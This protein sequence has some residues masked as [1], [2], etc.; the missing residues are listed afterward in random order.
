MFFILLSKDFF[1]SARVR[2][3]TIYTLIDSEQY[4]GCVTFFLDVLKSKLSLHSSHWVYQSDA[5]LG[6]VRIESK[7]YMAS[8]KVVAPGVI[9]G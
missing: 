5:R 4:V 3:H 2:A 8:A 7:T 9:Y 1:F 6:M